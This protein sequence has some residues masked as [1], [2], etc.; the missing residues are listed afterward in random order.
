MPD[1][2][3]SGVYHPAIMYL[4]AQGQATATL[5]VIGVAVLGYHATTAGALV[6]LAPGRPVRRSGPY[7]RKACGSSGCRSNLCARSVYGH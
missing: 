1:E 2:V 7:L 5:T 6:P 4:D 3:Q